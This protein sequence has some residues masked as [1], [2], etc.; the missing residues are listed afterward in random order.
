[1]ARLARRRS[2]PLRHAALPAAARFARRGVRSFVAA[3]AEA[4]ARGRAQRPWRD[5]SQAMYRAA[6]APSRSMRRTPARTRRAHRRR[7]REFLAERSERGAE[8]GRPSAQRR[9]QRPLR[10]PGALAHRQAAR[11]RCGRRPAGVTSTAARE[12]IQRDYKSVNFRD[13]DPLPRFLDKA[14]RTRLQAV[15]T[16]PFDR[17]RRRAPHLARAA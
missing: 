8:R 17:C 3:R 16:L 9:A 10:L 11:L 13:Q 15:L 12:L 7:P 5:S 4:D 2:R 14:E 6:W 1:M